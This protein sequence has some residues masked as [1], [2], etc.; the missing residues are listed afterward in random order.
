MLM[1]KDY[2]LY[3]FEFL[4][5]AQ[6]LPLS[7]VCWEL[8]HLIHTGYFPKHVTLLNVSSRNMPHV[9]MG[10]EKLV[11]KNEHFFCKTKI[12]VLHCDVYR[13][14]NMLFAKPLLMHFS[15][16]THLFA[17]GTYWHVEVLQQMLP[18]LQVSDV[19]VKQQQQIIPTWHTLNETET[20]E[21][22]KQAQAPAPNYTHLYRYYYGMWKDNQQLATQQIQY[23]NQIQA[24][25][26]ARLAELD[27]LVPDILVNM[28]DMFQVLRNR[29]HK[30]G[31]SSAIQRML[32]GPT[33]NDEF[34]QMVLNVKQYEQNP[35]IVRPFHLEN[36]NLYLL[37]R[38][39]QEGFTFE[40][41][42]ILAHSE[43]PAAIRYNVDFLQ[44]LHDMGVDYSQGTT[45]SLLHLALN[46][47]KPY[48][49][50]ERIVSLCP[51][52]C[53]TR[54]E[55][56]NMLHFVVLQ[57]HFSTYDFNSIVRLLANHVDLTV[58]AAECHKGY[59]TPLHMLCTRNIKYLQSFASVC[60]LNWHVEWHGKIPIAVAVRSAVLEFILKTNKAMYAPT[61]VV[62]KD[63]SV[64]ELLHNIGNW[65]EYASFYDTTIFELLKMKHPAYPSIAMHDHLYHLLTS[66]AGKAVL[67]ADMYHHIDA[68]LH[69]VLGKLGELFACLRAPQLY[70]KFATH[71]LFYPIL[72]SGLATNTLNAILTPFVFFR[73]LTLPK[74]TDLQ[75]VN[76]NGLLRD[77]FEVTYRCNKCKKRVDCHPHMKS[78]CK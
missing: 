26:Y 8:H 21:Q 49:I 7:R 19:M 17:K 27:C 22:L 59:G 58:F 65:Q 47:A 68:S 56:M 54:F 48:H 25:K 16:V 1:H 34:D 67:I 28:S 33:T 78:H 75:H 3:V 74:D 38:A 32:T 39:F 73:Q 51:Q 55:D 60:K 42:N 12:L 72:S 15:H 9:Q 69:K 46:A 63:K 76:L 43:L 5:S 36:C 40:R 45:P 37:A 14:E 31:F 66:S 44:M 4:H 35:S 2:W 50:I 10:L 61:A 71:P 62:M 23:L 6:V 70:T 29:L 53:S 77:K 24:F 52:I 41:Q 30:L 20:M 11:Q 18:H 64:V 57:T 13:F